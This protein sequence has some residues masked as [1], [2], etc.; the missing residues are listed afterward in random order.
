LDLISTRLTEQMLDYIKLFGI[1][2]NT[3]GY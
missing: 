2:N 3:G 1:L